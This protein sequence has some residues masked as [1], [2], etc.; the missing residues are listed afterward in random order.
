[1]D[2]ARLRRVIYWM[3][4]FMDWVKILIK[5]YMTL[6]MAT[7]EGAMTNVTNVMVERCVMIAEN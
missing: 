7:R 1:M 5:V 6:M 2:A 4:L 3:I